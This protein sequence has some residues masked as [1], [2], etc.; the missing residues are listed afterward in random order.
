MCVYSRNNPPPTIT[1][2]QR[3]PNLSHDYCKSKYQKK[4]SSMST[5]IK[6]F[7]TARE[8]V[9]QILDGLSLDQVNEIP[10]G[11]NNNLI[12]NAGH[13]VATHRGLVY[14]LAGLDSDLDKDFIQLYKKGSKPNGPV[15]LAEYEMITAALL[16]QV[17]EFEE[18]L[19]NGVFKSYQPYQTSF[20]F[21]ITSNEES[22]GFNNMHQ[23]L[24]ISSMMAIKRNLQ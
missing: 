18:D 14:S 23:A 11:F 4:Q 6:L 9:I 13:L 16:N 22:F 19:K 20:N 5:S 2:Y 15:D 24:H 7:R 8:N 17:D 10:E 3:D 1:L 12:W 21:E